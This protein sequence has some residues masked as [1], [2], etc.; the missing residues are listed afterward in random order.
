MFYES[1]EYKGRFHLKPEEQDDF[2]R[3]RILRV[4]YRDIMAFFFGQVRLPT[5]VALPDKCLPEGTN[6][7]RVNDDPLRGGFVLFVQHSSFDIVK[8]LEVPPEHEPDNLFWNF[9]ELKQKEEPAAVTQ[10]QVQP[11]F[12]FLGS[13]P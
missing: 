8:G 11:T 2:Y 7:L 3:I 4:G 12:V 5:H 6:L 1:P 13:G 9:Y 10:E